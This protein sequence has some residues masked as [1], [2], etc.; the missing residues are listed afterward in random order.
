MKAVKLF[1]I[2]NSPVFRTFHGKIVLLHELSQ[3]VVYDARFSVL[4]LYYIVFKSRRFG[5]DKDRLLRR[6]QQISRK[7]KTRS[8][9]S[10]C[11]QKFTPIR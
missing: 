3:G 7:R 2:K 6:C 8:R 1:R 9:N 5:E 11:S 4:A 10:R